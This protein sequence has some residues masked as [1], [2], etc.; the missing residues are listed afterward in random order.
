[1]KTQIMNVIT[2][3]ILT[4]AMAA[5]LTLPAMAQWQSKEQNAFGAT[6]PSVAFQ[7]TSAL[8]SSGSEYSPNPMLNADGTATYE[9]ASYTPAKSPKKPGTVRKNPVI[10]GDSN[11]PLGDAVL[12]LMLLLGAY[13]GVR[14]FR[15]TRIGIEE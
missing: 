7:S 14:S 2:V 10:G 12:P 5:V 13:A 11:T 9:G 6:A 4:L 3:K 8:P 1:M 15:R